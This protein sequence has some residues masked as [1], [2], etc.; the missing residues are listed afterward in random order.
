MESKMLRI[1][2]DFHCRVQA[3]WENTA[4]GKVHREWLIKLGDCNLRRARRGR[5]D[6]FVNDLGDF[7]T[8]VEIKSTTWENVKKA[9]VRKLLLS[10]NRQIWKYVDKYIDDEKT[11]VCPGIIY[12]TAPKHPELKDYIERFFHDHCVQLVWYDDP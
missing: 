4:E 10:H 11:D 1:G 12:P 9:N 5:M 3:D 6:I 7:V 8:V 2:K